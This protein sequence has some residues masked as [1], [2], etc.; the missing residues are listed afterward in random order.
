MVTRVRLNNGHEAPYALGLMR[1]QYRGVEVI[2]HGGGVIGG[3]CQMLTVPSHGLNIS[4]MVNGGP[5]NPMELTY[6]I[7][8]A[9]LGDTVLGARETTAQGE[10]FKGAFG[11]R[12][13]APKSGYMV[14]FSDL[15]GKLGVSVMQG[16]PMPIREEGKMLVA[17]CETMASG[18]LEIPAAALA[19]DGS[20]PAT[21]QIQE[22]GTADR[23]EKLPATAPA[24]AD[25]GKALLGRY[26]AADL[27]ADAE[28][29]F[30]GDVLQL[31]IFGDYGISTLTLEA[32]SDDVFGWQA[33]DPS[34]PLRS[35]L[36]VDRR[37]GGKVAS[38]RVSTLRSRHVR[39]E[40]IAG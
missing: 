23:F 34:M 13:Y 20:A 35:L 2:H 22:G 5:A 3:T 29:R 39:F 38:L 27:G 12:Y 36:N 14:A 28:V 18:T 1:H 9:M 21:L 7:V 26:H 19:G 8:D 24:L 6:K 31:R 10:R 33:S 37:E 25:A 16:P 17:G 30:V 15:E 4:M 32:F 40:R 11:A